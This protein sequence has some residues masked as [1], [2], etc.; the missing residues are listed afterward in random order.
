MK[1]ALLCFLLIGCVAVNAQGQDFKKVVDIVVEM[2]ASLKDMIAKEESQRKTEI[3][4]LKSEVQS[5]RTTLAGN[6][7]VNTPAPPVT[8]TTSTEMF[9]R[10]EAL[11]KSVGALQPSHDVTA[12]AG[13]LAT[14]I[15]EL[16]KTVEEARVA[17]EHIPTPTVAESTTAP[18]PENEV[19][20]SVQPGP[21]E[22]SGITISGFVDAYY[23]YN[24]QRP[25]SRTNQFRNFDIFANQFSLNFAKVNIAHAPKPVGFHLELALGPTADLVHTID[26]KVDETFKYVHQVYATIAVPAAPGL[27]V[28]VGKFVTHLGAEVIETNANWNYSRSLLF[29]WAIPYFH[30]GV[31]VTY[32]VSDHVTAMGMVANGWN[33]IVDNNDAKTFGAQIVWTPF[34][35]VTIFQNW[36][37][38]AEQA[39]NTQDMRTV[40]DGIVAWQLM[41]RLALNINYDLGSEAVNGMKARWSGIASMCRYAFNEEVAGS[42]RGE[43]FR[44][45]DGLQTGTPQRLHEVTAT[46]EWRAHKQL[47]LR[48]EFRH[49][50]SD[51][52]VF[53]GHDGAATCNQQSTL[54]AG[55]IVEF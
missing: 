44:D 7:H 6:S 29:A 11:E 27:T 22:T 21:A 38:G 36:I 53:D 23:G 1:R 5:L 31:R 10:V 48:I 18:I 16:K 25:L 20:S 55:A 30:T 14:L 15:S 28:D 9:Q 50:W 46:A 2:E 47:V 39:D 43:W 34:E 51:A 12:L 33:R 54:V 13:Q 40:W 3:A 52:A 32:P 8:T 19:P 26:G 35:G 41:D 4:S 17:Q 42:L 37:H 49:D 24:I 45:N